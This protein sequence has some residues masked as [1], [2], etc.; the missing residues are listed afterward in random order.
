M[1]GAGNDYMRALNGADQLFGGE[2]NDTLRG[3]GGND[4]LDGGNGNDRLLGGTGNDLLIGGAG[5]D[6][7]IGHEGNDTLNGGLGND[8]LRG[9]EGDYA[10]AAFSTGNAITLSYESGNIATATGEGTDSL[11]NIQYVV[12]SGGN[13]VLHGGGRD[14][15][16]QSGRGNDLLTGGAGNDTLMGGAGNDTLRG[17]AG[18]NLLD[19]GDGTDTLDY[20]EWGAVSID[21]RAGTLE[22]PTMTDRLVSIENAWSGIGNDTLQGDRGNNVFDGGRGNDMISGAFGNDTLRG[23]LGEDTLVG[24]GG[25]DVLDGGAEQMRDVFVFNTAFESGLGANADRIANFVSGTDAIDLSAIDG[26]GSGAGNGAF[27]FSGTTAAAH[28]VW[29]AAEA[30]GL[31]V[32]GDVNGDG[33]ADF[34]IVINGVASVTADDFLL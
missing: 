20:R 10:V 8:V 31:R 21:L 26:N 4:R 15:N 12:T 3:E 9:D 30:G 2:G 7:L 14:N 33:R 27:A 29:Y 19:G 28:S 5:N 32:S 18:E 25:V 23:G 13:D 6:S 17:D 24:G 34:S 11:N 1:G 22:G 16:F